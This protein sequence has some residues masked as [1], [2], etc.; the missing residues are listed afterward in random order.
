MDDALADLLMMGAEPNVSETALM[1]ADWPDGDGRK[2]TLW[3]ACEHGAH[4]NWMRQLLAGTPS[5]PSELARDLNATDSEGT[6]ALHLAV[7]WHSKLGAIDMLLQAGA[8]PHR[9]DG[10]GHAPIDLA[11]EHDRPNVVQLLLDA[12]APSDERDGSGWRPLDRAVANDVSRAT[13][14][15]L[16]RAGADPTRTDGAGKVALHQLGFSRRI[17]VAQRRADI[18]HLLLDAGVD[19]NASDHQGESLL[20]AFARQ[21]AGTPA[22]QVLLDHGADPT[23]ID[24]QGRSPLHLAALNG[25]DEPVE[26]LLAAGAPAAQGDRLGNHPLHLGASRLSGRA[27]ESL[28]QRGDPHARNHAGATAVE[29]ILAQ[30]RNAR[31]RRRFQRLN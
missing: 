4:P 30:H 17:N 27:L 23:R 8:D 11:V 21:R 2:L 24:A 31:V 28:L 18:A 5:D 26:L 3:L 14:L 9:R 29:L 19:P 25:S 6:T 16:L 15:N 13:L 10:A 20:H 7:R 22:L 1:L 12:G